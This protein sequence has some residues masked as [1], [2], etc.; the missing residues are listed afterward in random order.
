M[1]NL[2]KYFLTT[3][4]EK[5][6]YVESNSS[7]N[8]IHHYNVEI[9]NT[10]DPEIQ[11]INT[12]PV[13]KNKLKELLSELKKFKVQAILLL[14]YKKR[15]NCKIFHSSAKSIA[16]DSDIDEAF[17]YMYQITMTKKTV[18]VKIGLSW[19]YL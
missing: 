14:D 3:P 13:I 12:K 8:C 17:K 5:E 2:F 18:L 19:I 10:F 16:S 1:L 6:K 11:L 4:D 9:F 7:H 15:N